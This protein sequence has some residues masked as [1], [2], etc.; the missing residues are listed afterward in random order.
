MRMKRILIIED[1]DELHQVLRIGLQLNQDGYELYYAFNGREGWEKCV[2]VR[3]DLILLDLMMPVLNGVELLKLLQANATTRDI[4][5]IVMTAFSDK[6]E[7]L[8]KSA[9]GRGVRVCLRKPFELAEMRE[10]VRRILSQPA[11]RAAE[12]TPAP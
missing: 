3:P 1:D 2:Q 7:Q 11:P 4:P 5:V 10:L 8:E 9:Q 6:A 12:P